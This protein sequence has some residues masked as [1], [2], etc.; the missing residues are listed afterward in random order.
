MRLFTLLPLLFLLLVSSFNKVFAQDEIA[1][2]SFYQ[3][4]NA[5]YLTSTDTVD[6]TDNFS[7]DY[8]FVFFI[9]NDQG[10]HLFTIRSY[11]NNEVFC[12]GTIE[13]ERTDTIGNYSADVF[14]TEVYCDKE[15][16]NPAQ[17][18]LLENIPGS[19]DETGYSFYN[20]WVILTDYEAL[21][22]QCFDATNL[23]ADD[24][25]EL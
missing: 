12:L 22:F 16:E 3:I 1:N 5:W 17:A 14:A 6:I 7:N 24:E 2:Y 18:I 8:Y 15:Q 23:N 4:T 10:Q 9:E 20:V 25:D 19:F 21:V 11:T 13:F